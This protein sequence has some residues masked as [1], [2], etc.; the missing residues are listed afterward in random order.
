MQFVL[1]ECTVLLALPLFDVPLATFQLKLVK[2]RQPRALLVLLESTWTHQQPH[3]LRFVPIVHME[4]IRHQLPQ[5]HLL[6][7]Y[8]A[9]RENFVSMERRPL[10]L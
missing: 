1:Q 9:L 4:N 10:I 8:S 7:A 5:L 2:T 3:H 6:S